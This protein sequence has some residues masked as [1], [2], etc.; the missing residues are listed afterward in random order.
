MTDRDEW[1]TFYDQGKEGACVG[2]GWSRCMSI[3]NSK[4]DTQEYAARWLWDR[5]K[6][7]DQ[8]P[9]TN[10]GDNNGTSVRSAAEILVAAGHVPWAEDYAD[11]EHAERTG[12]QPDA[13]QGLTAF[14]WAQAVDEVHGVLANE[15]ADELSAVPIL[16]SWGEGYPARVWMP[17]DVLDR[18][19]KEEGEIAIPTDR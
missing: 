7:R 12:Y 19:M 14:R 18:L 13:A 15:K 8:W 11:D 1:R 5:A 3:L 2:F 9:E 6:E 16:N 17:D 4:E 10:P